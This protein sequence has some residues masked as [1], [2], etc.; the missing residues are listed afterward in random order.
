MGNEGGR[1]SEAYTVYTINLVTILCMDMNRLCIYT[2]GCCVL[3]RSYENAHT[4][5]N[6]V[7]ICVHTLYSVYNNSIG[8]E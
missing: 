8:G 5:T 2:V 6:N 4:R 1:G 3:I 7:S